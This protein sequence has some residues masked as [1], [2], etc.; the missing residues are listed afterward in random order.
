M[1]D[2]RAD[3]ERNGMP[4]TPQESRRTI[5]RP[6]ALGALMAALA[7]AGCGSRGIIDR[8]PTVPPA[9]QQGKGTAHF[10]S[11]LAP[12][13]PKLVAA[14]PESLPISSLRLPP[15]FAIELWASGLPDARMMTL[16]E[17]GTVFVGTRVASNVYA[18]VDRGGMREVK[19]I[20]TG[21]HRP[22]GVAFRDGALYVAEQHRVIRFDAIESRL[23]QPPAPAVFY[24]DLPGDEVNGWRVIAFGPDGGL[25]VAISA[26]CNICEPPATHAQI[27]RIRLNGHGADI[28]ARGVRHALGM[29][30]RPGTRELWFTDN[31]RDWIT[32]DLPHDELNRVDQPGAHFG[33]PYCHQGDLPDNEFGPRRAC[34]EFTPPQAKLGPHVAALG[35]R[36]Y[37]KRMFPTRYRGGVFIA[38]HGSWNRQEKIGFDVVHVVLEPGRAPRVEPFLEGF[39]DGQSFWGRPVDVLPMP[40]GSLLVSDDFAGAIYRITFAGSS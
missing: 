11:K 24:D 15:G 35:M 1:L 18:I 7:I 14:Q 30:W 22:N 12:H 3:N 31:G 20:A 21:L 33:F 37:D 38:R 4:Q 10:G 6:F 8:P 32:D 28:V 5:K 9:W 23:D 36:F 40:D 39:L 29:D 25:H 13:A 27:R 34:A 17:R 2:S 19:R 16:G 26:A